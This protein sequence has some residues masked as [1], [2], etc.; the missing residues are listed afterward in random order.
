MKKIRASKCDIREVP[1]NEER[2][3]LDMYHY[4]GFR[5]SKVCYGLYNEDEL[6]ELMSF[7]KPRYNRKYDW[8]LLR[9]CTKKDYQVY[10]GASKLLKHFQENY[11]GSIVSYCNRDKFDGGVYKA[12]GFKSLG[13]TKGYC[14]EK[15]GERFHRSNFTKKNCLKKWPQYIDTDFTEEEIMKD[16]GYTKIVE[17]VG[18]ETFILNDTSKYYIYKIIFEDGSTYV[19]SHIQNK[20][21]DGYV[22]SSVYAKNHPIKDR[23]IL[24]WLDDPV[25]MNIMETICIIEDRQ[26]SDRNVNGNKGNYANGNFLNVGWNKGIHL[27]R[28][29]TVTDK[30][31]SRISKTLKKYYETHDS[32][33]KGKSQSEETRK[34]LSEMA[35][36]QHAE[37]RCNTDAL[38]SKEAKE[39]ARKTLK[40]HN[41]LLTPEERKM[42]YGNTNLTDEQQRIAQEALRNKMKNVTKK[43][44]D[45]GYKTRKQLFDEGVS[46]NSFYK[47]YEL[48]YKIG[49][50]GAYKHK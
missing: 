18:Q 2:P 9:L 26:S 20:E 31:K 28:D 3:F 4:Q 29:Y 13:V 36:K 41:A 15:N 24:I 7:C 16:Q 17:K 42:K 44:N 49:Q 38:H 19:G 21:N 5:P 46:V 32:P 37:G 14:Y 43:I 33:W 45:D 40:E 22:T 50:T 1:V 23:E 39:K 25:T 6:I 35:K 47:N 34:H 12:L 27:D 8:E 30:T 48:V 11:N 10:G